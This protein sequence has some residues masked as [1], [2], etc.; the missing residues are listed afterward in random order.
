MD[1]DMF[2]QSG[3]RTRQTLCKQQCV[4]VYKPEW[5]ELG[6]PAGFTLNISEEQK[7]IDPVLGCLDMAIHQCG[8]GADTAT[9]GGANHFLPL[10]AGQLVTG[11]DVSYLIV[12]NF[13]R[14][15]RQCV[16]SV[17]SQHGEI[18]GQWHSSQ[19]DAIHDF[20]R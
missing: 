3:A 10:C 17:V 16:E 14:G 6:E 18:V 20:H 5:D 1:L 9:M 11:K 19:L 15:T 8:C 12:E 7:L 13:G 2:P 4:E